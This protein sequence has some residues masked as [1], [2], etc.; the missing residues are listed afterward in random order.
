MWAVNKTQD[1]Y[2]SGG[3]TQSS[4]TQ[5][6]Y[7]LACEGGRDP[8][9]ITTDGS[10]LDP[11]LSRTQSL[12]LLPP[13]V[14]VISSCYQI[15]SNLCVNRV[16]PSSILHLVSEPDHPS[17]PNYFFFSI[18]Y[19]LGSIIE[20]RHQRQLRE[21][22]ESAMAEEELTNAEM[23]RQLKELLATAETKQ[24]LRIDKLDARFDDITNEINAWRPQL[25]GRP[26]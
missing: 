7:T 13:Q 15:V 20:T 14:S 10:L 24:D 3:P 11:L 12:L 2:E 9:W 5:R 4:R 26:S 1:Q 8:S 22:Q 16:N 6:T 18:S 25:E 19:D 23:F 17:L 21:A